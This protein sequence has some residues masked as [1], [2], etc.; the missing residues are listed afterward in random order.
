MVRR[1][2]VRSLR[3]KYAVTESRSAEGALA[4][5]ETGERFDAILCDM[6]MAGMSGRDFL[7]R[8]DE[9][10]AEAARRVVILSGS[11][12]SGM[13]E[14]FL[15]VVSE[16]FLEKPASLVEIDAML[17]TLVGNQARAA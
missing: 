6:N 15:N 14:D 4:L 16:R 8:L 10:G 5:L 1:V 9:M 2:L 3:H 11:P 7:L 17:S 12:R 13:D